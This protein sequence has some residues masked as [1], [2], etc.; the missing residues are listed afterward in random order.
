MTLLIWK[1]KNNLINIPAGQIQGIIALCIIMAVIPFFKYLYLH[2]FNYNPPDYTDQFAGSLPVEIIEQRGKSGIYFIYP[3]TSARQLL[4]YAGFE[5]L[6]VDDFVVSRGM[7]IVVR[8]E[9]AEIDKVIVSEMEPFRKIALGIP[10]DINEAVKEDLV[11]I[12][13]IGEVTAT[14][15]IELRRKLGRFKNIEQLK[16]VK[17]IKEKKLSRLRKYLFVN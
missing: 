1:R 13:G 17:G 16:Q 11:L 3:G 14:K 5:D 10:I 12:N 2:Y 8:K 6:N 7:K 15:I 4:N 9:E